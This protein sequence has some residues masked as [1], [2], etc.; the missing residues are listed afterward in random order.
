MS[1]PANSLGMGVAMTVNRGLGLF[2]KLFLWASCLCMTS[3]LIINIAN[4]LVR[5]LSGK[6]IVWVWPWTGVLFIWSVFLGFYVLYRRNLD[7]TLDFFLQRMPPKLRLGVRLLSGLCAISMMLVILL[8][9]MQVFQR[10]VGVMDFIG[11]ERYVLSIPLLMSS[12]LILIHFLN[13]M[14]LAFVRPDLVTDF[15]PEVPKWSL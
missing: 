7:V 6:G 9:T 3:M 11:L 10:Q 4:L 15:P 14:L 13:D 12:F 2:E 5:N 1:Q 8:Q